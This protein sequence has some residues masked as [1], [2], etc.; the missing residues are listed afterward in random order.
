MLNDEPTKSHIHIATDIVCSLNQTELCPRCTATQLC[1]HL[2]NGIQPATFALLQALYKQRPCFV[3]PGPQS[4]GQDVG[5][6]PQRRDRQRVDLGVRLGVVILDV[7]EIGRILE[8]R[9]VPIQIPHPLMNR[10]IPAPDIPNI[11]LEVLNVNRLCQQ[12]S[13]KT[14]PQK[15]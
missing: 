9:N 12:V 11:A 8:R 13:H 4:Q 14:P 6:R 5:K 10:R 15:R 7:Q 1:F 3:I 2:R